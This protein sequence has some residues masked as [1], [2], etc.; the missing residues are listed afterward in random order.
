MKSIL[1]FISIFGMSQASLG[2]EFNQKLGAR[3][4]FNALVTDEY[5]VQRELGSLFHARPVILVF[6]YYQCPN[7]CTLIL[8]GL[9]TAVTP[10]ANRLGQDFDIL[11]LSINPK[12][13]PPLAL[14]KKRSYL[15]R[16]GKTEESEAKT[17][18]FLTAEESQIH[19][20]TDAA[21]FKYSKDPLSG[22]YSH[23][24]GIVIV[25]AS[26][27]ISQ[28]FFGI[29]FDTEKLRQSIKVAQSE[30]QGGIVDSI[31]LY[32]FHYNPLKSRNGALIMKTIRIVGTSCLAAL[33]LFLFL[34][35]KR[36]KEKS[37]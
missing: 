18:H 27:M 8:N 20:L 3:L 36:T 5:G 30:K 11:T 9:A 31:L 14:A 24:S 16:I 37:T 34:L 6:A 21:G 25:S 23:P 28:Y 10:I 13:K 1:I 4:P 7:L 29:S 26:G 2:Q 19:E 35:I 17:W 32:C 15:A 22:E 33:V 12:E